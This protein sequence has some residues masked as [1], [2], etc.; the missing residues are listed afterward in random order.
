MRLAF[1]TPKISV[2][3]HRFTDEGFFAKSLIILVV[4]EH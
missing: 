4:E 2:I 3:V 1:C